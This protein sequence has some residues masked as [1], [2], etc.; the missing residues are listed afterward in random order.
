MYLHL[1][2]HTC[3]CIMFSDPWTGLSFV[4]WTEKRMVCKD[5][6]WL[7]KTLYRNGKE[8]CYHRFNSVVL[9]IR[10]QDDS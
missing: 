7:A 2:G 1:A 10:S 9:A 4:S 5:L 6:S 8:L 3:A